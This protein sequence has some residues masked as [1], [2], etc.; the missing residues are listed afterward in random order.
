MAK[1]VRIRD[2]DEIAVR[3]LAAKVEQVLA[4]SSNLKFAAISRVLWA[5]LNHDAQ[6]REPSSSSDS[7]QLSNLTGRVP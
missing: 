5:S 7:S 2:E 4:E 3:A 1:I 6:G